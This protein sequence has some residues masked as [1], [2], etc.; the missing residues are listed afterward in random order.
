MKNRTDVV[1]ALVSHFGQDKTLEEKNLFLLDL[2]YSNDEVLIDKLVDI[3]NSIES[4]KTEKSQSGDKNGHY[5]FGLLTNDE[6]KKFKANWQKERGTNMLSF[7][8]FDSYLDREWDSIG[9][10]LR[11]A[12]IYLTSNE[13]IPFWVGLETDLRNK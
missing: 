9:T 10:F 5:W 3:V 7:Y 11:S 12:F 13:G 1:S 8:T 4:P 6:Q 2:A